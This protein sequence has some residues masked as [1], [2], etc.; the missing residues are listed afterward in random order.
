MKHL[1]INS[2]TNIRHDI[3]FVDKVA[4]YI[5]RSKGTQR[6]LRAASDNPALM[7]AGVS[8]VAASMLRPAAQSILPIKD[9]KDK[10]YTIGS[11]VATGVSELLLTALLFIPANK[12][13]QS[14]SRALYSTTNPTVYKE[15]ATLL[16]QVKSLSNRFL[17]LALMPLTAYVRFAAVKPAVDIMY[18]KDKDIVGRRLNREC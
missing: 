1:H 12:A 11:S 13:I 16:R 14:L 4:N 5:N 18:R 8:F 9:K 6:V 7:S 10:A 17:K 3:V 15:N 2:S